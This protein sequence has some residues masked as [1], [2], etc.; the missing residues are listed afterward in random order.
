MAACSYSFRNHGKQFILPLAQ[1]TYFILLCY[2]HQH[3]VYNLKAA[4]DILQLFF[5]RFAD[6]VFSRVALLG[7][8]EIIFHVFL[9]VDPGSA[10]SFPVCLMQR[11]YHS[12]QYSL[13]IILTSALRDI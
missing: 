9:P 5:D 10:Y 8:A 6:L 2:L 13:I 11:I 7:Q 4:S 1:R 12:I 3:L